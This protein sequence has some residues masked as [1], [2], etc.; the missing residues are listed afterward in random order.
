MLWHPIRTDAVAGRTYAGRSVP[1]TVQAPSRWLNAHTSRSS[2]I[3]TSDRNAPF[4]A[5]FA[6]RRVLRCPS[7]LET[8]DDVK[9]RRLKTQIL[10]ERPWSRLAQHYGL[11][12]V[13][14]GPGE[15]AR[16]GLSV[17]EQP[18]D[19]AGLKKRYEDSA[20]FRVYEIDLAR[21]PRAVPESRLSC[22]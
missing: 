14:V 5:A 9:R 4:V 8:E 12:H 3:L 6:G 13:L 20:H 1:A 2:V 11:T 17:A 18:R 21:A 22:R 16:L 19:L 10:R 7:F 15:F